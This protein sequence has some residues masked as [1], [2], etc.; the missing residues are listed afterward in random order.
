MKIYKLMALF[1]FLFILTSCGLQDTKEV[2][3]EV[4]NVEMS[5][6]DADSKRENEKGIGRNKRKSR[7]N[8]VKIKLQCGC[9]KI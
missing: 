7:C 6:T 8:N 2:R 1:S 9:V 4:S 5:P 3:T